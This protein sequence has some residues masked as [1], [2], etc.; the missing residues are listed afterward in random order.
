LTRLRRRAA[1]RSASALAVKDGFYV[2]PIRIEDE[3]GVVR[4]V[5]VRPQTRPSVVDPSCLDGCGVERINRFAVW[6]SERD[7]HGAGSCFLFLDPEVLIVPREAGSLRALDNSDAE[8]LQCT[9]VERATLCD[10]THAQRHVIEQ[11]R[12]PAWHQ[13]SIPQRRLALMRQCAVVA[14]GAKTAWSA[15]VRRMSPE[16]SRFRLPSTPRTK[17]D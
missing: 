7:V 5:I 12:G 6:R 4:G 9:L 8:G 17:L 16:H 10:V 2:V 1:R 14:D 3:C 13:S 15:S 11:G